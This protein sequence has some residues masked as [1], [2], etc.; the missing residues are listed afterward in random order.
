MQKA[1]SKRPEENSEA[2]N[3]AP[4]P[5]QTPSTGASAI[6]TKTPTEKTTEGVKV[7]KIGPLFLQFMLAPLDAV[8]MRGN[9][10]LKKVIGSVRLKE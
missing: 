8:H 10:G 2:Q 5:A 4:P 7:P 9:L 1:D 3:V 6:S